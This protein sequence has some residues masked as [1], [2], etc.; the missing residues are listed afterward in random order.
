MLDCT[1]CG[2]SGEMPRD[3]RASRCPACGV[4]SRFESRVTRT[5]EC[6]GCKRMIGIT[7]EDEGKTVLCPGCAYFLGTPLQK[8]G[9][10]RGR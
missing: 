1:A 9:R 5:I 8:P 6:P 10:L 4:V 7:V 3:G 2:Y